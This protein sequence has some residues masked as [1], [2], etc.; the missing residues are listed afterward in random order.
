MSL[1]KP[2][3]DLEPYTFRGDALR[4]IAVPLGGIGTGCV[5][6]DGRGNFQDWEIYGR[7]NKGVYLWQTFPLLW[8]RPEGEEARMIA[9]QGPR[10]KNWL[11]EN[12]GVWTYGH[13]NLMHQ[14]D[15]LPCFD[16]VEF[17]GTFPF[18]RVG[19]QKENLPL[20]VELCAFNPFVPLDVDASSY[21]GAC[22]VYRLKNTSDRRIDA[23]LAWSLHNPVGNKVPLQP[24]EKEACRYETFEGDGTRGIAFSN[25]RFEED[26]VHRG[27]VALSTNWPE[28]TLL[29]QWKIGGWFDVFQEFW[30]E[31]KETGRLEGIPEGD[32]GSRVSGTV[33][34]VVSLEPGEEAEIP[35]FVS[36]SFPVAEKYWD[37]APGDPRHTWTPHYAQRFPTAQA[38]AQAFFGEYESLADR[39]RKFEEALFTSTL[40]S[41]VLQSVSATSSI[42]HSPTVLRLQDGEFWAWEGCGPN[43]GCCPGSCSHVWNY[44]LAHAFLF[45]EMQRS[46]RSAEYKHNFH[47]G[48]RGGEGALN[49]RVLIPLGNE[50]PLWHAASD[51]QLG[52]VVQLYRDWR[53]QGSDD[54]L[55]EL[56]PSAKRALEFAWLQWDLDRDGLTEG[57]QHN[58][59]DINFQGPNPLTQF[60]YLAALRAGEEIAR[61]L[62]DGATADRYRALIDSGREKTEA[63]LWNGEYF[64]QENAYT[65]ADAPKYQHGHGC[66][67][68]QVFGQLAASLAGLGD[69]VDGELIRSALAAIYR[70]N[71]RERLGD[72]EN[73]QRVFAAA[74]EP[75]LLLCSWPSGGRPHFPF[76]YSDEVWTGIEYQVA[77][78]LAYEGMV[79][80]A[81]AI[82]RG[83]RHRYDG[84]RR[85]PWNEVE[86]GSHYARA[87][88]AYGL[89]P[90]L[91]GLRYDAVTKEAT[92]D[93]RIEGEAFRCFFS[94][95]HGWGQ[96]VR[97]GGETRF[98]L[99]EGTLF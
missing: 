84:V 50:H 19:F 72:H 39:T 59:Y 23:T 42:L 5:S 9:V 37:N 53:L 81:L 60:F 31:F 30:D 3:F 86:C 54:L 27:T 67:S 87:M 79:E 13:G 66:L 6:L 35:F 64:V 76:V 90:A 94:T 69:L 61:H 97:E 96:A 26:S 98:E 36:W 10:V 91:S 71:F 88:A 46:M 68:D 32:H 16:S 52:G 38:A 51:G 58:T 80:E 14:M 93:P 82:V 12:D 70:H 48:P 28:T 63:R 78:H 7:P 74:D 11:G 77:T 25:D 20:E 65:D 1:F 73:L 22:L 44:S 55:N 43:I 95:P 47:C 75:G 57:D 4:E 56:W 62:G 89:L 21:P 15:G 99:A 18:S 49:F 40:P 92:L 34:A 17:A 24:E 45:P 2:S 8:M 41:E 33:G 85:N 83:V 29:R